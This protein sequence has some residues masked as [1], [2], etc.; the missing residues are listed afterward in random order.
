MSLPTLIEA[1][2]ALATGEPSRTYLMQAIASL[3]AGEPAERALRL[4]GSSLPERN[5]RIRAA[6]AILAPGLRPW[7]A[8]GKVAE[9]IRI[10]ESTTWVRWSGH[11]VAAM[12]TLEG[13]RRDL[14]AARLCGE[15]PTTQRQLYDVLRG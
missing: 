7:A 13:Y 8:A 1:A 10:F 11:P 3:S 9:A 5:A 4:N 2:T 15:L 6:A 14:F 12:S